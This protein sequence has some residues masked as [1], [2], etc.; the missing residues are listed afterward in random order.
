MTSTNATPM[1]LKFHHDNLIYGLIRTASG[2]TTI[3][4]AKAGGCF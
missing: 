4:D 1:E 2:H 3:L